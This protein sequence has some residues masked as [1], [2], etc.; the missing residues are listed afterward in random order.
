MKLSKTPEIQ[1]HIATKKKT[2]AVPEF[3][4]IATVFLY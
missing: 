2:T 3:K 1:V 4:G